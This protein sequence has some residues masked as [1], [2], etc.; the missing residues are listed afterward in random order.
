MRCFTV[1][2]SFLI[3]VFFTGCGAPTG[4]GLDSALNSNSNKILQVDEVLAVDDIL[5]NSTLNIGT[6]IEN[7][8]ITGILDVGTLVTNSEG[9]I[10]PFSISMSAQ[11]SYLFFQI[12]GGQNGVGGPDLSGDSRFFG[13][14]DLDNELNN[15][16]QN[17]ININPLSSII[18]YA[19]SQSPGRKVADLTLSAVSPFFEATATAGI[20]INSLHYSG[21]TSDEI[22]SD[23]DGIL[24]QIMNEM[25]RTASNDQIGAT[26]VDKIANFC[27]QV[28]QEVSLGQ[29]V[30]TAEGNVFQSL[31]SVAQKL[32]TSPN[33]FGEFYSNALS[34][35][36]TSDASFKPTAFSSG[37]QESSNILISSQV[38]LDNYSAEI[39]SVSSG[40]AKITSSQAS[41]LILSSIPSKVRFDLSQNRFEAPA[42]GIL[43]IKV[44]RASDDIIMATVNPVKIDSRIPFTMIFPEGAV[45]TGLRQSPDG[46]I[47][48]VATIN[49]SEDRFISSTGFMEIPI[50][51]LIDKGEAASGVVFP[52]SVDQELSIEVQLDNIQEIKVLGFTSL[53]D[54]FV[55]PSL[56]I[57]P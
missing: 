5:I 54:T 8:V 31:S 23:G 28:E 45:I 4:S 27:K 13:V 7:G 10:S 25:I 2:T 43:S 48:N 24:F 16:V 1:T 47:L 38:Y 57:K 37:I 44:Q 21:R 36:S 22:E 12:S 18:S 50:G 19:K 52:D 35:L 15:Q 55:I 20:D 26:V 3:I 49:Q 42:Q 6:G 11:T 56:Q 39:N 29:D 14:L 40:E 41:T 33:A 17:R 9:K 34:I 32:S 30:F 46:S 53:V 51:D